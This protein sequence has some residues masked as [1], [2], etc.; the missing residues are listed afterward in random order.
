[1]VTI[2]WQSVVPSPLY[3]S[4]APLPASHQ[5]SAPLPCPCRKPQ[6]IEFMVFSLGWAGGGRNRE[7]KQNPRNTPSFKKSTKENNSGYLLPKSTV[8]I[9]TLHKPGSGRTERSSSQ[10]MGL[11]CPPLGNP[12][13]QEQG[14]SCLGLPHA[15]EGMLGSLLIA[16]HL[17]VLNSALFLRKV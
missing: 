5:D 14:G 8:Y 13:Q 12:L 7:G 17:S 1:M 6:N 16:F 2:T 3:V 11:G 4:A 15:G 9:D 10:V